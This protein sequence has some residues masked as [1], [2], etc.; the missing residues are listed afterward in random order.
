MGL[1][2]ILAQVETRVAEVVGK[3]GD[4]LPNFGFGEAARYKSE[5]LPRVTWVPMSGAVKE[6][7]AKTN[8]DRAARHLWARR[9]QVQVRV[10]AEDYDSAEALVGHVF[11]AF[12]YVRNGN[13]GVLSE[14]WDT[15]GALKS[16]VLAVFLIEV[17]MPF[18][19]EPPKTVG[20]DGTPLGTD[21]TEEIDHG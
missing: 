20:G 16:G 8:A 11:A 9:L 19:D 13:Y 12:T 21:L 1:S 4:R 10:W 5:A 7:D 6:G 3:L 17:R 2:A 18:A 15:S 14:T